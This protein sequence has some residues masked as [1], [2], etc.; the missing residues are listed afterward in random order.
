MMQSTQFSETGVLVQG[1]LTG[2]RPAILLM[3]TY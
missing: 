1:Y 2:F 3:D